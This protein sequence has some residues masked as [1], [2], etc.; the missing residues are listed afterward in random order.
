VARASYYV[1]RC[2]VPDPQHRSQLLL[3]HREVPTACAHVRRRASGVRPRA[4]RE[5]C[6][7]SVQAG[8]AAPALVRCVAA[9]AELASGLKPTR[10]LETSGPGASVMGA[11]SGP[12]RYTGLDAKCRVARSRPVTE[13]LIGLKPTRVLN[14]ARPGSLVGARSTGP[15]SAAD[16]RSPPSLSSDSVTRASESVR[17][18]DRDQLRL[19]GGPGR[20][21]AVP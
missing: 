1:T 14:D 12:A 2:V 7:G 5:P 4:A 19:A 9:G 13:S 15:A 16:A 20:V 17:D 11:W 6:G 3:V 18:P 21:R 10:I 8:S